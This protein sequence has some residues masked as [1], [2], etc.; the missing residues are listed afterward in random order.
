[1]GIIRN[2]RSFPSTMTQN[3][4]SPVSNQDP[5]R[6]QSTFRTRRCL[7][8]STLIQTHSSSFSWCLLYGSEMNAQPHEYGDSWGTGG[9]VMNRMIEE[10]SRLLQKNVWTMLSEQDHICSAL[11]GNADALHCIQITPTQTTLKN[12]VL[13]FPPLPS[14]HRPPPCF[15]TMILWSYNFKIWLENLTW[16]HGKFFLYLFKVTPTY[17]GAIRRGSTSVFFIKM[18]GFFYMLY[19]C[20]VSMNCW[21]PP[22]P[23]SLVL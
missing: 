22:I 1:M 11:Q 13:F 4:R 6:E 14:L 9:D 18:W 23:W 15:L 10:T 7:G 20:D 21:F 8:C 16:N 5:G 17:Y 2:M 3:P 19:L 12:R